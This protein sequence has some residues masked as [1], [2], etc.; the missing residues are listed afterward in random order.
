MTNTPDIIARMRAMPKA[1]RVVTIYDNGTSRT[2]ETATEE[3]ANNY[4]TGDRRRIGKPLVDRASGRTVIVVS[5][6][7]ERI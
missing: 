3:Q 2:H 6:T 4:A 1:W 7:V 5:V